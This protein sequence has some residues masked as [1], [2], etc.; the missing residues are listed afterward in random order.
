[1]GDTED[2]TPQ[3]PK[4]SAEKRITVILTVVGLAGI[5]TYV[6]LAEREM[7]RLRRQV[8]ELAERAGAIVVQPYE[9][10]DVEVD[11]PTVAVQA[12]HAARRTKP[13]EVPPEAV[14]GPDTNGAVVPEGATAEGD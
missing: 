10:V 7:R 13:A 9:V 8:R 2:S 6:V 5:A 12:K 4:T 14:A 1:V 3:A 11:E